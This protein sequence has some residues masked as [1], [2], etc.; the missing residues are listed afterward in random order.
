RLVAAPAAILVARR[1][2]GWES[3]PLGLDRAL[4]TERLH[5]LRIGPLSLGAIHRLLRERLGV[6][7][8][9]PVLVRLYDTSGGNPFYALE[10][11]RALEQSG[12][13]TGAG[14]RLSIP[15][16]LTE[17]LSARLAGL[18]PE[19][20]ALLEPVALLS[21]PTL[22]VVAAAVDSRKTVLQRL[23]TA[24]DAAILV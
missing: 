5:R 3:A 17:L 1:G 19:V 2:S 8:S 20:R 13:H 15:T 23:G 16:S 12:G 24:E 18:P 11:G 14:E 7:F 10:L 22:P 4:P 21:R 6:S 9:R